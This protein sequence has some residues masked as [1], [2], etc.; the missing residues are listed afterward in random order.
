MITL[1]QHLADNHDAI[2]AEAREYAKSYNVSFAEA[3]RDVKD[4][5]T[6]GYCEGAEAARTTDWDLGRE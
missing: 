2:M 1:Q 3:L 4:E 5:Y 6:Q